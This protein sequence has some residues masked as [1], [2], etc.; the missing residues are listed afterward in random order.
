MTRMKEHNA[1]AELNLGDA[2][3]LVDPLGLNLEF[4]LGP[5]FTP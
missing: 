5:V 2:D 4:G 1:N 3:H